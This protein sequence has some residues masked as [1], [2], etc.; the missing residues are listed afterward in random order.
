[1]ARRSVR[2]RITALAMVVVGGSLIVGAIALVGLLQ[3]GLLRSVRTDAQVRA[4]EV[5]ALA[6]RAPLPRPLPAVTGDW[7]TL[8]Q[9]VES[10]GRVSTASAPL[11]DHPALLGPDARR[12]AGSATRKLMFPNGTGNGEWLIRAVRATLA[13][14]AATVIVATSLA[15]P[16]RT[17][18]LLQGLLAVGVPLLMSASGALTW[19][20]VG[21]ALRPVERLR[22]E[23]DDLAS[24]GGVLQGRR[25][26]A[27]SSGDEIERLAWT[28][29][30]LLERVD[31]AARA[32]R[33]FVADASHELRGPVANIRTALEVAQLHPELADWNSVSADVL[34]QDSRMGRLVDDLLL[35]ARGDE[36][37]SRRHVESLD[38]GAIAADAVA[39]FGGG[40]IAVRLARSDR[41]LIIDDRTQ[42]TSVVT[43]VVEN[44]VRHSV[45]SVSVSVTTAGSWVELVVI[46]DGPGVAASDRER[47]FDRF[48]R[49]DEHRSRERGGAGLG[50]AIVAQLVQARGG[51]VSVGDAS[52]GA[53]FT[54][55]LPLTKTADTSAGRSRL[56][57]RSDA[58]N[59]SKQPP[60]PRLPSE[61][62]VGGAR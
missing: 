39:R 38:L 49:V 51:V 8:L 37:P 61:K 12:H 58:D 14:R 55:R 35:L 53:V 22:R 34:E 17:V 20:V 24:G 30:T 41:A 2:V 15:Q 1:M 60:S 40:R 28:L 48:V 56:P 7:P 57:A 50:L 43:N 47:I 25:V 21:R 54:I 44:A 13:S 31:G 16:N 6:G 9:V 29:N 19:F 33:R 23:V 5:A 3:A 32:Q 10:N 52:P 62:M 4:A 27:A 18:R 45:S 36:D 11:L 42:L 46:D 26:A 59:P